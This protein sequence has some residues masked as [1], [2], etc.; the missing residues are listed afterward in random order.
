[1][2]NLFKRKEKRNDGQRKGKNLTGTD[3]GKN[4][5]RVKNI[6]SPG[7]DVKL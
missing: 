4:A 3:I 1:M 2:F 6:N 7:Q 5:E